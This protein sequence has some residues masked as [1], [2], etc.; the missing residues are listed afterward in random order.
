MVIYQSLSV[1]VDETVVLA[2]ATLALGV[3][4][5]LGS[6]EVERVDDGQGEGTGGT[7]RTDVGAKFHF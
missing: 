5:Q 4:G 3:G 2:L 1:D 6:A 7:T